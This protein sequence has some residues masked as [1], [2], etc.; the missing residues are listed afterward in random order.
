MDTSKS[1]S[2]Y[3]QDQLQAINYR[4]DGQVLVSAAAGSGKTAVL[5]QR[6][7]GLI[8][9]SNAIN[10]DEILVATFTD[11]AA[12]EMRYRLTQAISNEIIKNPND[13]HLHKQLMILG[14]ANIG[15]LHSFCLKIVRSSFHLL[16]ID[17]NF[18]I[19]DK[20]E[21]ELLKDIIITEIFEN[22][23]ANDSFFN[24]VEAYGDS[25]NS[26]D[27]NIKKTVLRLH[28]LSKG[29]V[30]PRTWLQSHAK[31]FN[32][33]NIEESIWY[34]IFVDY[35][36]DT[37]ESVVFGAKKA[38]QYCNSYGGPKAY[39]TALQ[40]DIDMAQKAINYLKNYNFV[41]IGQVLSQTHAKLSK[42][43][44]KD[45]VSE[46]LQNLVK[47]IRDKEIKDK[48]KS[49]N[50][51][52]IFKDSS[53]MCKDLQDLHSI[54][55]TLVNVTIE[56]EEAFAK[57]KQEK[58]ILDFSDIEHFAIAALKHDEVKLNFTFY[59]VLIDEYQDSNYIQEFI[60]SCASNRRF[61]V[62]DIKQSIY[63]FRGAE[64]ELFLTKYR[65]NDCDLIALSKNFR[66][67]LVI[68]NTVNLL[69]ST[70]LPQTGIPYDKNNM[71]YYGANYITNSDEEETTEIH[72]IQTNIQEDDEV[73]IV[74]EANFI[75]QKIKHLMLTY[76]VEEN[77]HKRPL[78]YG[79][80]AVLSRAKVGIADVIVEVLSNY[81]IPAFGESSTGFFEAIEIM[82]LI[83]FLN[84]I[85]NP[86]QDI[87]ILAVLKSHLYNVNADELLKIFNESDT[88]FFHTV[89]SYVQNING[90]S[91]LKSKLVKFLDDLQLYKTLSKRLEISELIITLVENTGYINITAATSGA[92]GIDNINLFIEIAT[93]Q[94]NKSLYYFIQYIEGLTKRQISIGEVKI[95]GHNYVNILTIHKSK[96]LEFPVVFVCTLGRGFNFKETHGNLVLHNKYGVGA[97]LINTGLRTKYSTI[98]SV[99]TKNIIKKEVLQEEVRMLYVAAT[100][101]REKLIF[102]GTLKNN[103]LSPIT[104]WERMSQGAEKVALNSILSEASCFFD[105]IMPIVGYNTKY[106]K[107]TFE[108]SKSILAKS[109]I[110]NKPKSKDFTL[111]SDLINNDLTQNINLYT[112]ENLKNVGLPISININDIKGN[113]YKQLAYKREEI[114]KNINTHLNKPS[115]LTNNKQSNVLSATDIGNAHHTVLEHI[116][117]NEKDVHSF[118]N[119]LVK[120]NNLT[121]EE[122]NVININW[123]QNF[124]DSSIALRIRNSHNLNSDNVK[125][126]VHFATLISPKNAYVGDDENETMVVHGI[127]DCYFKENNSI[128]LVDY[129]TDNANEI[130]IKQRY[131]IQID[132]YKKAL[133]NIT[134]KEV[135]EAIIYMLATGKTISM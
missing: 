83:S 119:K 134:G 127:V 35:L 110:I 135:K 57:A 108:D 118:L 105:L 58:N 79:D 61:M 77:G 81:N 21:I 73:G 15:T 18:K 1:P 59:E 46:E 90:D 26:I 80:I 4:G 48:I 32:L 51:D 16:D 98:S 115:F 25:S 22:N 100:R 87:H 92:V 120:D 36:N 74:V 65:A 133:K 42:I 129:K 41:A 122:K 54:I 121:E 11:L 131:S 8:T 43:S 111:I 86:L 23:Y 109:D 28:T 126:E 130:I 93:K 84:I 125:K 6:I 47:S 9:G 44:K 69:F 89:N 34:P 45:D 106:V 124:L 7:M 132:I 114:Q 53:E 29:E 62:G 95:G 94:Q 112:Y 12:G 33:Q 2:T 71:L 66:S 75:A 14:K 38:I 63:K 13:Y 72:V 24:L 76:E 19:A 96:G 10:I 116:N 101:A 64:P 107:V 117:I 30:N 20:Q 91:D 49:L 27:E 5:I 97:K 67:R 50:K 40:N 85:D 82:T 17:P 39:I 102:T 52:I 37:L 99:V 56:F 68:I 55:S 113:Y 123:I 88:N 3:T 103:K 70:L 78:Q 104:K 31:S 128:I 60:I